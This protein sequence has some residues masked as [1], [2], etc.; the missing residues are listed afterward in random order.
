MVRV[1]PADSTVRVQH[2]I[3]QTVLPGNAVPPS[4]P[5]GGYS[6][7]APA[8]NSGERTEAAFTTALHLRRRITNG[9][10]RVQHHRAGGNREKQQ[11]VVR[12]LIGSRAGGPA[13]VHH[14]AD[15][16]EALRA[17]DRDD[18]RARCAE[19]ASRLERG[20]GA[21]SSDPRK[22]ASIDERFADLLAEYEVLR[23]A[24]DDG[25]VINNLLGRLGTYDMP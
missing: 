10:A 14:Y 16:I 19:V 5:I 23:D 8:E 9:V 2:S 13:L 11:A 20:W 6:I 21:T 24:V 3:Q 7:P 4:P 25:A 12:Q 1:D 18:L 17:G 15:A 22:Q